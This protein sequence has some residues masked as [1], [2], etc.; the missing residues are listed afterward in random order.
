[1][2]DLSNPLWPLKWGAQNPFPKRFLKALLILCALKAFSCRQSSPGEPRF[3]WKT[4]GQPLSFNGLPKTFPPEF[5][6]FLLGFERVE[7][8]LEPGQHRG[9]EPGVPV[10][11]GSPKQAPFGFQLDPRVKC[12]R[13]N[14]ST[15][16]P[17][18]GFSALTCRR[19]FLSV[20]LQASLLFPLIR[21]VFRSHYPRRPSMSRSIPC[22]HPAV[23]AQ[24]I[25]GS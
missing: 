22:R 3:S 24:D 1:M 4:R 2:W 11:P 14:M 5:L 19:F 13:T 12:D 23:V 21:A 7:N 20:I 17:A 6:R 10:N 25:H 18:G 15:K 16:G 9:G 8:P